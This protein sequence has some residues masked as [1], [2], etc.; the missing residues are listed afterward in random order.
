MASGRWSCL[1][2]IGSVFWVAHSP[3]PQTRL[4]GWT[5]RGDEIVKLVRENF[6]DPKIAAHWADTH[7]EYAKIVDGE[8]RFAS[9]TN[10]ILSELKVSHT[11]FFTPADQKY[12]GLKAIFA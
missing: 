4:D 5:A 8:E 2:L 9:L 11:G 1:L 6:Y 12:Y 3:E 10:Q 7:M